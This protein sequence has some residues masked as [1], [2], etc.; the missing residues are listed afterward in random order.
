MLKVKGL[1]LSTGN[2]ALALAFGTIFFTLNEMCNG[3]RCFITQKSN[4]NQRVISSDM[5]CLEV[6]LDFE[7]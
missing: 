4:V 3:K 5:S 1:K 7:I 6:I 2:T